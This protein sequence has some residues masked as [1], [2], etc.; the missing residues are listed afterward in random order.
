MNYRSRA[1][2]GWW[3]VGLAVASLHAATARAERG[4]SLALAAGISSW[5][6][7]NL[8][9]YSDPQISQFESG[10]FPD[11][12]AIDSIDDITL[13]PSLAL[14]WELDQG[15]G[16]RHS[17]RVRGD[18]DFHATNSTADFQSMSLT[19]REYF[20]GGHRL[21]MRGYYL[22]SYYLRQLRDVSTG[23]YERAEFSLA[24]GEVGWV[25][26]I[27]RGVQISFDFQFERRV[28]SPF[29]PERT[30]NTYQTELGL[31]L[32]RLPHRGGLDFSLA[33]RKSLADGADYPSAYPDVSYHGWWAGANGRMEFGGGDKVR[34]GGDLAYKIESR[35]YDSERPTD[36]S[37]YGRS[38]IANTIEV[39]LLVHVRPHWTVRAFEHFDTNSATYAPLASLSSDPGS[40]DQN[41]LGLEVTWN[42]AVWKQDSGTGD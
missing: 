35:T 39:G 27:K 6:D 3:V 36:R 29:F 42:G 21:S 8:L 2:R 37:H 13:G 22:P 9:Q 30:S 10:A 7:S 40:Y 38:D 25:Q 17:V 1:V 11:R 24:I 32:D 20:R 15:G 23:V 14:T 16:R 12:F 19:W 4:Q 31:G 34:F 5:Y 33:Y 41:V 28:Y 26:T 18:G